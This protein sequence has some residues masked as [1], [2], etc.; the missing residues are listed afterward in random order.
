MLVI[1]VLEHVHGGE[2]SCIGVLAY[3][4]YL[5]IKDQSVF[6]VAVVLAEGPDIAWDI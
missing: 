2:R 5:Q 6:I 4:I 3:F 1:M